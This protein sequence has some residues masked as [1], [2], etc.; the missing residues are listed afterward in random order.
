M[1]LQTDYWKS[2]DEYHTRNNVPEGDSI[3]RANIMSWVMANIDHDLDKQDKPGIVETTL[4]V[5][6]GTGKNLLA[7]RQRSDFLSHSYR[8]YTGVEPNLDAVKSLKSSGLEYYKEEWMRAET[9][10]FDLVFTSGVLIH[11]HPTDLRPFMQKIIDTSNK[12]VVAIEYF[13]PSVREIIYRDSDN[14]LWA[15]DY[16]Q[17]Y[18]NLGLE[19]VDCKFFYKPLTGL[20]NVTAW[21]LRK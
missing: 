3:R 20:D 2:N 6:C 10:E 4:E 11:V 13:S 16:G 19:L 1:T 5:G 15:N 8:Q 7:L 14:L 12:Y 9:L 18:I 21:I 17:L